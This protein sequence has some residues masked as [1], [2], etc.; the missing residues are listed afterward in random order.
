MSSFSVLFKNTYAN[1]PALP[2]CYNSVNDCCQSVRNLNVVKCQLNSFLWFT[3][4]ESLLLP[5]VSLNTYYASRYF[6]W[7]IRCGEGWIFHTIPKSQHNY[8]C[9]SSGLEKLEDWHWFISNHDSDTIAISETSRIHEESSEAS[10]SL[11]I[12][13]LEE[14]V[15]MPENSLKT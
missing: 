8:S 12:I 7:G 1:C 14:T 13:Q 2:A 15:Q 10:H 11:A 9:L 5:A 4:P 6:L 3:H